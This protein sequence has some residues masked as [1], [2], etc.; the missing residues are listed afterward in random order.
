MKGLF[1][2]V[3]VGDTLFSFENVLYNS[4]QARYNQ[5]LRVHC[6]ALP[7]IK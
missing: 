3:Q 1:D 6:L 7:P 2:G 5:G 4:V